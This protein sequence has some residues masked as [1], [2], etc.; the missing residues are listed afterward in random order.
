MATIDV[1]YSDGFKLRIVGNSVNEC[2]EKWDEI[3]L[4]IKHGKMKNFV[5]NDENAKGKKENEEE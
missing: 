2:I 5:G 3:G 1:E 4:E